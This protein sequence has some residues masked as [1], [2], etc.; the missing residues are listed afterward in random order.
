[1]SYGGGGYYPVTF[2]HSFF[3]LSTSEASISNNL[4]LTYQLGLRW[5]WRFQPLKYESFQLKIFYRY[6]LNNQEM[7]QFFLPTLL[8]N[9]YTIIC[10]WIA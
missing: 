8:T 9:I 3:P 6:S 2:A 5:R 1:M 10:I 7:S 4:T